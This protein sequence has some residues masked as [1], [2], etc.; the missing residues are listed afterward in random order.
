MTVRIMVG[1]AL[2]QLATLPGGSVHC[3]VTSPPYWSLRA[4]KADPGMIGLEPT[5]QRRS[6]EGHTAAV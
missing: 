6:K 4:Y 2:S 3:V 5:C 1:D